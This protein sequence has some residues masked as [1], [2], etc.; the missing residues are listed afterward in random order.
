MA[1][2]SK[3]YL[4]DAATTNTG[5]MP[6]GAFQFGAD[7]TG[8]AAGALTA[9]SANAVIGALQTSATITSNA[10]VLAQKWGYRRFV[11][12]PLVA[13]TFA[14]ADG[15]WTFSYARSENNL[16]HNQAVICFVSAWRPST[17]ARV[18]AGGLSITGAEPGSAATQLAE[19]VT[20]VWGTSVTI[21]TGD[22]LVF[23]VADN[24]T[25]AMATAYTST[26]FYDGTTEASAT[27]CASFITPP[28]ALTL[29]TP[30]LAHSPRRRNL[31][32]R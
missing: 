27:T 22:I 5:T 17:G 8:D 6:T 25:Q 2:I 26:F 32:I 13:Q 15:N 30:S 11:S 18:G 3:F 19:S 31:V 29:E 24:F 23:E 16:N 4:H 12:A 9:R 14:T 1:T 21:L 10:D 28:A 20:G 7:V